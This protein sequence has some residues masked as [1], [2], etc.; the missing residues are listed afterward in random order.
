M[1]DEI[2]ESYYEHIEYLISNIPFAIIYFRISERA[3]C[4]FENFITN[5][6]WRI[7]YEWIGLEKR[8]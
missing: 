2:T 3:L 7:N 1:A 6:A 4:E 8:A 5:L